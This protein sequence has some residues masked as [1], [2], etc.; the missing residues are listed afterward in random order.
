LE[1]SEKKRKNLR[2]HPLYKI[3]GC[4]LPLKPVEG[5]KTAAEIR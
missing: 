2:A 3:F 1:N 4:Y 5:K